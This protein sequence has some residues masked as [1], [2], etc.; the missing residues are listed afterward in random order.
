VMISGE[1]DVQRLQELAMRAGV[2]GVLPKPISCGQLM[3]L[4]DKLLPPRK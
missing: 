3:A 4:V 2:D 1:R